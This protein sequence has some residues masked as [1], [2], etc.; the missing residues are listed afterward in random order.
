MADKSQA[1]PEGEKG[2][3]FFAEL[4]LTLEK[5]AKETSEENGRPR[6]LAVSLLALQGR[7]TAMAFLD[8]EQQIQ[9][10]RRVVERVCDLGAS[11]LED[12]D[13]QFVYDLAMLGLAENDPRFLRLFGEETWI[14][15]VSRAYDRRYPDFPGR[16][17]ALAKYLDDLGR[18]DEADGFIQMVLS[19][20][21]QKFG[22]P[23]QIAMVRAYLSSTRP[24]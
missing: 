1:N 19:L 15:L 3:K 22:K 9:L 4:M 16:A 10:N 12:P 7:A 24:S 14:E 17:L 23:A 2:M 18:N 8:K 5:I 11:A 6:G 21:A 13:I 20:Q